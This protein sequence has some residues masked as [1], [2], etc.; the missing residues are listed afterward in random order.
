MAV[1]L[2]HALPVSI[3]AIPLTLV[4]TAM[5]GAYLA[6]GALSTRRV[7]DRVGAG[8]TAPTGGGRTVRG[9]GAD[10]ARIDGDR[11]H[12]PNVVGV[13]GLVLVAVLATFGASD[14][15]TNLADQAVLAMLWGA[16]AISSIAL[17]DWWGRVDPL[18]ALSEGLARATGDPAR[19]LARPL[20]R[21]LATVAA[22]LGL[23]GWAWLQVLAT[24]S[25]A[26]FQAVLVGWVA[27]HLVGALRYGPVWLTAAEPLH[28][29]SGAMG[30]LRPGRG[31]PGGGGPGAGGPGDG[32]PGGGGPGSGRPGDGGPGGRG[33]LPRLVALPDDDRLRWVSGALIGWS[34]TD[35]L[36]E[37][38]GWHELPTAVQS[39]LGPV[40][41]LGSV[42]G[43]YGLIRAVSGR[44][45]LGPAF[46]AVAG[47][48]VVAHYLSILLIEG[49]GLTIWLSDPFATGADLLGRRGDLIDLEP[50]PLGVMAAI[51]SIPFIAGH[52]LAVAVVQRRAALAVRTPGQ[53][54]AATF[55]ARTLIAVLLLGGSYLQLGGA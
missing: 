40:L 24:P 30:L 3:G 47:A 53:L 49:Q 12:P 5:L 8:R 45:R 29:V 18:L 36:T 6:V 11:A 23:I 1:V 37:A 21:R 27:L 50:L 15:S 38:E 34:L 44:F 42:V 26:L 46:V 19:E 28:V 17:G 10:E 43:L 16:V 25:V 20:P 9:V 33:P 52:L 51:Q 32:G 13:V 4:L 55:F 7:G 54:G 31:G 39:W 35:L 48:W 2:L 14:A 22:V 41:L